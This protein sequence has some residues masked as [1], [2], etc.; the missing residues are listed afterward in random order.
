MDADPKLEYV[1][2]NCTGWYTSDEPEV[3]ALSEIGEVSSTGYQ[4]ILYFCPFCAST[5]GKKVE[6]NYAPNYHIITPHQDELLQ[7]LEGK[8]GF[9]ESRVEEI[10][11]EIKNLRGE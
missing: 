2:P 5:R 9:H 11:A 1:C 7:E 8:L 6:L 10:E 3:V 4:N